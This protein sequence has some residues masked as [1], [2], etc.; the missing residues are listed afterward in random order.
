MHVSTNQSL[1]RCETLAAHFSVNMLVGYILRLCKSKISSNSVIRRAQ[2]AMM[3][4]FGS[5]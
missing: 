3:N 5:S 4:V 1:I 2:R